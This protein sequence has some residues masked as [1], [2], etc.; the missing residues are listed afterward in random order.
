MLA[1][2]IAQTSAAGVGVMRGLHQPGRHCSAA[3]VAH[4]DQLHTSLVGFS[5]CAPV[6]VRYLP[7][8]AEG[9]RRAEVNK[10]TH[11]TTALLGDH[12]L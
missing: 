2:L 7:R 6:I 3:A 11:A 8:Q 4:E 12:Y 9:P 5:L 10:E 1:K